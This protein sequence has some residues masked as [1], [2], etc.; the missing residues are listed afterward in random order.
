MFESVVQATQ[1]RAANIE[2]A[3]SFAEGELIRVAG[4]VDRG[5]QIVSLIDRIQALSAQTR[6]PEQDKQLAALE[7]E[8]VQLIGSGNGSAADA[9]TQAKAQRW[10][11][12]MNARVPAERYEAQLAAYRAA[13]KIYQAQLYFQTLSE[14]LSKARVYIVADESGRLEMRVNAEDSAVGNMLFDAPKA[15]GENK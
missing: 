12:H 13:P 2:A 7:L 15:L 4:S 6:T 1:T 11:L 14:V 10:T 3:Q 9:L 5:R 8:A